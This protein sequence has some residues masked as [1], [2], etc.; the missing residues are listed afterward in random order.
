MRN[1]CTACEGGLL[2]SPP[3]RQ[4]LSLI[5]D[6][7]DAVT[8]SGLKHIRMPR[9]SGKTSLAKCAFV[10]ALVYGLRRYVVCVAAARDLSIS[11]VD[12]AFSLVESSPAFAE[13]F[14][15]IAVPLN[16][17]QERGATSR[18]AVTVHGKLCKIRK[19]AIEANLPTVD[20]SASSGA[21][22]RAVGV[23]G[24]IR[25]M[26]KG[27]RRPDLV[28]I[29][30]VQDDEVAKSPERVAEMVKRIDGVV[31]GLGGRKRQITA[32]MTST[33]IEPDDV[34]EHYASSPDWKTTTYPYV[35]R[36]PK[37]WGTKDDPWKEYA[38]IKRRAIMSGRKEYVEANRYYRTHRSAMDSGAEVLTPDAYDRKT[39]VSGLQAAI[40]ILL[41]VGPRTF[42]AE[43]QM[44]PHRVEYALELTPKIVG[45]RVRR[46]TAPGVVPDGTVCTVAA[47]DLN[48]SYG[49]TTVIIAFDA[50]MTGFI[51]GYRVHPTRISETENETAFAAAVYDHLAIVGREV[52]ALGVKLSAWG[53]DAGGKQ[54]GPVCKFREHS[55]ELCGIEST[56][57]LGRAGRNWNPFVR[58]QIQPAKNDT[59]LCRDPD[60][61][62][63]VAWN[64]D[65]W[66]ERAQ[67][68]W[69]TEVG[70]PGGLSLFD[71]GAD[72]SEFAAQ[73]AGERLVSKIATQGGRDVYRWKEIGSKHD[74]GDV[75]AMCFAL[76]AHL[77]FT[78][79]GE[80]VPVRQNRQ[81][82]MCF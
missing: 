53:V 39:E 42:D 24:R 40:N 69:M 15:E 5:K 82:A 68:A 21:I 49:F 78:D 3:S 7:Q 30:D 33:P 2:D 11:M 25:G 48:P 70:S 16:H 54:F 47:T 35:M 13:D 44:K 61:R 50:R 9:G 31:L 4:M 34:S 66:K 20:G 14:P 80:F 43:Y 46:G 52:S 10:Y 62:Q 75:V 22:I 27:S 32:L 51:V 29:D 41:R 38:A 37:C 81:R 55:L 8:G 73:V 76:A 45:S 17:A 58:S 63:W 67:K 6:L 64:A 71:G 74:Y 23:T 57:M 12:D 19:T 18:R 59:V 60:R 77:G 1:Y 65:A 36:W 56:P 72:H 28:V 26:V 79:T